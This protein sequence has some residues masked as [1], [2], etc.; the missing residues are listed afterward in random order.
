MRLGDV[1]SLVAGKEAMVL[2]QSHDKPPEI[3]SSDIDTVS[4]MTLHTEVGLEPGSPRRPPTP[5]TP[6]NLLLAERN[7]LHFELEPGREETE[8]EELDGQPHVR[9]A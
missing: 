3:E 2:K 7:P 8:E 9:G 5:L 6:L 4:N 1:E